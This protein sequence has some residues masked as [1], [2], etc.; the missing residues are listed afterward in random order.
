MNVEKNFAHM[1]VQDF[2]TNF[3]KTY[4]KKVK[5]PPCVLHFDSHYHIKAIRYIPSKILKT[6]TEIICFGQLFS[7]LEDEPKRMQNTALS[8]TERSGHCGA[9]SSD[10]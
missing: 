9:T 5:L 3:F 10:H 6:I 8:F 1:C 4:V 2:E 7:C